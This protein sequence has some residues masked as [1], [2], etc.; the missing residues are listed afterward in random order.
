MGFHHR[1]RSLRSRRRKV[2]G[3]ASPP[4]DETDVLW[5]RLT[6]WMGDGGHKSASGWNC[7]KWTSGIAMA[8]HRLLPIHG[9]VARSAAERRRGSWCIPALKRRLEP[10]HRFAVPLPAR[11][12]GDGVVVRRASVPNTEPHR[13]RGRRGRDRRGRSRRRGPGARNGRISGCRSVALGHLC[14]HV[15]A[16]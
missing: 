16:V 4:C 3:Q 13:R 7:W 2:A 8:E 12:G 11:R 14:L 10:L 6:P 15:Q 1:P 5:G 9:E